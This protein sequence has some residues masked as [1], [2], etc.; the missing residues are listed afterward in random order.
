MAQITIVLLVCESVSSHTE[1]C[2]EPQWCKVQAEAARCE[3]ASTT[4]GLPAQVE[5]APPLLPH[6]SAPVKST[7][8]KQSKFKENV[9]KR[10]LRA[11]PSLI[12]KTHFPMIS[13]TA[14]R[15]AL[16]LPLSL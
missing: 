8:Q 14:K 7:R 15:S 9:F 1:V 2:K 12:H 6:C 13:W 4:V 10:Q 5:P 3:R 11:L 16:S